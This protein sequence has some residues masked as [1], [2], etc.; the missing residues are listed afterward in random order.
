MGPCSGR[1]ARVLSVGLKTTQ[2]IGLGPNRSVPHVNCARSVIRRPDDSADW[3]RR[4]CAEIRKMGPSHIGAMIKNSWTKTATEL[5]TRGSET[6]Q[7]DVLVLEL[8]LVLQ[9]HDSSA[10]VMPLSSLA[11]LA[12]EHC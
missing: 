6:H 11:S 5:P 9:M 4:E 3:S 7:T 12:Y 1:E 10:G 2:T 8:V